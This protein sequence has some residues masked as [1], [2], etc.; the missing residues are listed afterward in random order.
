MATK[1]PTLLTLRLERSRRAETYKKKQIETLVNV[2]TKLMTTYNPTLLT[3]RLGRSR[4]A[5]TYKKKQIETLVNV[6]TK[7]MAT[8]NPTLLTY[9]LEGPEEPKPTK[10]TNRNVS[11]RFYKV[12]GDI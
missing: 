11:K 6:S 10:K 5:E 12:N 1:N 2:S 7:L 9:F 4:R 3:L 8:Y